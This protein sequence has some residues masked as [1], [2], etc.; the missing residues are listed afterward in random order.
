MYI[1]FNKRAEQF[2]DFHCTVRAEWEHSDRPRPWQW[3]VEAQL[4]YNVR[5]QLRSEV[6]TRSPILLSTLKTMA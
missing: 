4:D 2:S 6:E 3:T 1:M 5:V